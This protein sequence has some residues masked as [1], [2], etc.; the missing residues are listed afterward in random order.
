MSDLTWAAAPA[1]GPTGARG[2]VGAAPHSTAPVNVAA[3]LGLCLARRGGIVLMLA[4]GAVLVLAL[5]ST[6]SDALDDI[7][8]PAAPVVPFMLW[9]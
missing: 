7:C 6:R 2:L 5:G 4:N 1:P 3:A 8:S 9:G